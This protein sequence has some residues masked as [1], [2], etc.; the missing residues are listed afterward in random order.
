M[1]HNGNIDNNNSNNKSN[2]NRCWGSAK[3]RTAYEMATGFM[4]EIKVTEKS[5]ENKEMNNFICRIMVKTLLS[6]VSR[7]VCVCVLECERKSLCV[8]K[9]LIVD[10]FA[11]RSRIYDVRVRARGSL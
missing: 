1:Q 8:S 9:F 3:A 5:T 4:G 7:S 10:A 6:L 2:N 11:G